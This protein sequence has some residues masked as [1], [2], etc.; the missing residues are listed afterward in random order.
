MGGVDGFPAGDAQTGTLAGTIACPG[1]GG[2]V[3]A[4]YDCH[5]YGQSQADGSV[6]FYS[7]IPCDT[8]IRYLC[9]ARVDDDVDCEW[10]YTDGLNPANPRF[11][12]NE[13]Q[14][15]QW[16][17]GHISKR[18]GDMVK[19]PAAAWLWAAADE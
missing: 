17:D 9:A 6:R 1:C 2:K 18:Q 15:P 5:T 7:C 13:E 16:L 14:R 10:D 19:H 3:L 8:A 12:G 4:D 11:S